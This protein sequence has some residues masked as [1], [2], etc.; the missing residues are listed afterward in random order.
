MH[1]SQVI[2][3]QRCI[4]SSVFMSCMFLPELEDSTMEGCSMSCRCDT[5]MVALRKATELSWRLWMLECAWLVCLQLPCSWLLL[6][7]RVTGF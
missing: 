6:C 4:F 2:R 1:A 7:W 3:L 5:Q